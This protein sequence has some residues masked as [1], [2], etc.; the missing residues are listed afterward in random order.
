MKASDI[1]EIDQNCSPSQ[2]CMQLQVMDVKE[3]KYSHHQQT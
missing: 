2:L 1:D 3:L